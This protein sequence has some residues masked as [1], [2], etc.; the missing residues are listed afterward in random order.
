MPYVLTEKLWLT[1]DKETAVKD[2]D[3]KA[4]FLLGSKGHVI[5]DD[6]AVR[7]GLVNYQE[8]KKE[9]PKANKAVFPPETKRQSTRKRR[10]K[11]GS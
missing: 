4:H 5:S 9:E 1:T 10:T 11:K 6:E 8:Q 2:G 3:P 7:L